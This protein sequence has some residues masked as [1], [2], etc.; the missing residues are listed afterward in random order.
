MTQ[1]APTP[2]PEGVFRPLTIAV[3]GTGI[4][5]S[6]MTRNLVR[7]GHGVRVWNRTHATASALAADGATVAS[8]PTEAVAEADVVLTMLHDGPVTLEVM[9]HAAPGLRPGTMWVQSATV[10]LDL[11]PA[12]AALADDLGITLIDAPVLGTREPAEL[13]TLTVLAAGP[14]S[15]RADASSVFDAIAMRTFWVGDDAAAGAAQRLKLVTNAWVLAVNNATG[16]VISLAEGLGVAP[17]LFLELIE[18]GPLDMGYLRAKAGLILEDRLDEASFGAATAA[19]DAN[20]ILAAAGLADVRLDGLEGA[21]ARLDRVV[22][23]G[24]GDED[25]AAAYRAS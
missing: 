14:E 6:A 3:L 19:K 25:M 17:E 8:T 18:D 12:I 22:E 16:E 10:G 7:A 13:G 4:M 9:S 21:R 2:S 1:T 15:V 5:G 23:E 24:H 20:L 11:Q